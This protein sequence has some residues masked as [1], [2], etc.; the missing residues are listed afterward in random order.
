MTSNMRIPAGL[1]IKL[2]GLCFITYYVNSAQRIKKPTKPEIRI[3][4][5]AK[6]KQKNKIKTPQFPH[7]AIPILK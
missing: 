1:C 3:N 5:E 7:K 6:G 4:S 2:S